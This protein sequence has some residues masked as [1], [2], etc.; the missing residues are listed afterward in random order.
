MHKS[1]STLV[2]VTLMSLFLG[3]GVGLNGLKRQIKT[4]RNTPKVP[5][6]IR[7][8]KD[9]TLA[10]A[11]PL[12]GKGPKEPHNSAKDHTSGPNMIDYPSSEEIDQQKVMRDF[13]SAVLEIEKDMLSQDSTS[14]FEISRNTFSGGRD[15]KRLGGKGASKLLT[16]TTKLIGIIEQYGKTISSTESTSE[17]TQREVTRDIEALRQIS[18]CLTPVL[19][20]RTT[21]R[22]LEKITPVIQDLIGANAVLK[23]YVIGTNA[24]LKNNKELYAGCNKEHLKALSKALDDLDAGLY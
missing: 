23:K 12:A 19:I 8:G 3:C 6:D 1:L 14:K 20:A 9:Q 11:L 10:S 15:S 5:D 18:S 2:F 17:A 4:A 16:A 21:K 24:V 13:I 22:R 7:A